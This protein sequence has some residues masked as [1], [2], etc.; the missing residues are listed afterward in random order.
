M[1]TCF[2]KYQ[3]FIDTVS[4]S[5]ANYMIFYS[6]NLEL[7][8]NLESSCKLQGT[9]TPILLVRSLSSS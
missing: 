1:Y 5:R 4:T 9:S 6:Q 8:K 2:F 3:S 7:L